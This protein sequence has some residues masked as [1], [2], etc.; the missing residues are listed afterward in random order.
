MS[1]GTP[2]PPPAVSCVS[3]LTAPSP[4]PLLSNRNPCNL[5]DSHIFQDYGE[6]GAL[7]CFYGSG[8]VNLS[9][10]RINPFVN[11]NNEASSYIGGGSSG[12]NGTFYS[13]PNEGGTQQPWDD[14][15]YGNFG[16]G[17]NHVCNDDL[18]SIRIN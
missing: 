9:D 8:T 1:E 12:R 13:F 11:W 18:S 6:Q 14:T 10:W 7:I 17:T 2:G 4:T 3:T 5:L 15:H 16:C